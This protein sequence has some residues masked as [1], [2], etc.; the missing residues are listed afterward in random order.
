VSPPCISGMCWLLVWLTQWRVSWQGWPSSL[1]WASWLI[2]KARTSRRSSRKVNTPALTRCVRLI[3]PVE[4]H[5]WWLSCRWLLF[6]CHKDNNLCL[7]KLNHGQT[8][9]PSLKFAD[10]EKIPFINFRPDKILFMFCRPGQNYEGDFVLVCKN[11]EILSETA[12]KWWGC[13]ST[14]DFVRILMDLP[15]PRIQNIV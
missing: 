8:D 11:K 3:K 15:P 6:M 1:S 5:Q 2:V 4:R 14:G 10:L 12:F 7:R 13:L 9:M